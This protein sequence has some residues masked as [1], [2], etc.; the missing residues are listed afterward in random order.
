MPDYSSFI[1]IEELKALACQ[2]EIES[3]LIIEK[4]GEYPWQVI[5][6]P[7]DKNTYQQ[8][9]DS[10]W[11]LLI[12]HVELYHDAAAELLRQ[13]NFIPN[14]RIDDL[15][16]SYAPVH[17]SVGPHIDSYDVFL[18]QVSGRRQW[19]L[20]EAVHDDDNDF[21]PDLDLRI[22]KDF[23]ADEEFLL[24]PGDMLYLPP[25]VAHHGI[26]LE[27]CMTYSIGFRAPSQYELVSQYIDEKYI[28]HLDKRYTDPDLHLQ[29]FAG[30]ITTKNLSRIKSMM[31][32]LLDNNE[33]I[34][35]WF[36]DFV[37][38][39]PNEIQLQTRETPL[40]SQAV[41]QLFREKGVM[42]KH[43]ACRSAFIRNDGFVLFVN[44]QSYE[45]PHSCIEFVQ[46]FTQNHKL[47]Y[48]SLQ[49]NINEP[50][51]QK[52]LTRLFNEGILIIDD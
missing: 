8:L 22:I 33:H 47:D 48:E 21:I 38:N 39:L 37:T 44:G 6:G 34:Y 28:S 27:D 11:S 7:L 36:G 46:L 16:I 42:F 19:L 9:P 35:R 13:F 2:D 3:R 50:E 4:D 32:S 5:H 43:R 30:E 20:T 40:T 14:W 15:M 41:L 25:G 51:L 45:L 24:D 12:Q 49:A 1:T 17:S 18:L 26:A 23:K 52:I 31:R 29:K 10:H